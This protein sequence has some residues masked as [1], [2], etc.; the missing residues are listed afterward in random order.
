VVCIKALCTKDEWQDSVVVVAKYKVRQ[1]PLPPWSL[2]KSVFAP[3]RAQYESHDF[4]DGTKTSSKC[5]DK[6]WAH[7]IEKKTFRVSFLEKEAGIGHGSGEEGGSDSAAAEKERALVK[8]GL[9]AVY[10]VLQNCFKVYAAGGG[11]SSGNGFMIKVNKWNEFC[12]DCRFDMWATTP[13]PASIP[14]S[15]KLNKQKEGVAIPL[16]KRDSQIAEGQFDEIFN[17]ANLN[18]GSSNDRALGRPEFVECM[19]RV[20]HAKVQP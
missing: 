9:A 7:I 17:M 2:R 4:Y 13:T 3:R 8:Q 20:A 5:F 14:S 15:R 6:D 18:D 12:E 1:A 11:L 16:M 19:I 10:P